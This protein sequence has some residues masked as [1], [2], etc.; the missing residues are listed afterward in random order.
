VAVVAVIVIEV[1]PVVVGIEDQV[2]GFG[3][4]GSVSGTV[5]S[6]LSIKTENAYALPAF[7]SVAAVARTLKAPSEPG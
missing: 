3:V 4:G 7:A 1:V 6:S 2:I 5:A